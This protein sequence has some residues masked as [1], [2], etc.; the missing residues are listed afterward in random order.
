MPGFAAD[1]ENLTIR[2]FYQ[3]KSAGS[4]GLLLKGTAE[5]VADVLQ[6]QR[7]EDA[8]QED[9]ALVHEV[10]QPARAR[11]LLELRARAIALGGEKAFDPVHEPPPPLRGQEALEGDPAP[12]VEEA[13]VVRCHFAPGPSRN[14]VTVDASTGEA[15]T[16]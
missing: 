9:L 5:D 8:L 4:G 12:L 16:V 10:G 3:K 13:A 7:L 2:Q 15:K 6:D 11:L 14:A 1:N